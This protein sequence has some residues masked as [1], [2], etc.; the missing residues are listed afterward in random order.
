MFYE[1]PARDFCGALRSEAM[2]RAT[3]G[4]FLCRFLSSSTLLSG[5]VLL[6]GVPAVHGQGIAGAKGS[7]AAL[8]QFQPETPEQLLS[9]GQVAW[10]LDRIT[11]ARRYLKQLADRDPQSAELVLLRKQQGLSVFLDLQRD[12]RLHPESQQL[13]K[14]MQLAIVQPDSAAL[15]QRVSDLSLGGARGA[16]AV[17]DLLVAGDAAV[18]ALLAAD[19]AQPAGKAAHAFLENHVADYGNGLLQQ[20]ESADAATAVRILTLLGGSAREEL[21][22]P[23]VRWQFHSDSGVSAAA[24]QAVRR[25]SRG[26]IR[27]ATAV[28]AAELLSSESEV[29][30]SQAAGVSSSAGDAAGAGSGLSGLPLAER[31]LADAISLQPAAE[32]ALQLQQVLLAAGAEPLVTAAAGPLAGRP[33]AEVLP[34]LGSALDLGQWPAAIECLR[35]LSAQTLAP[36]EAAAATSVLSAAVLSPDVRVRVLAAVTARRNKLQA[37]SAVFAS[38]QVLSAAAQAMPQ[39]EA[40]VIAPDDQLS[41]VLRQL[42]EDQKYTVKVAETGP[43]GFER[44]VECLHSEVIFLSLYPSRWSAATTLANLRAD[45]RTRNCPVVLIGRPSQESQALALQ[46]IHGN[47]YFMSEPIG[48]RS[49]PSQLRNLNLRSL[50]TV[51]EREYLGTLAAPPQSAVS[52]QQ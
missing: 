41:L 42:L 37:G 32:R 9:A 21:A 26:R 33:A 17:T 3:R 39:S 15:V 18:P 8:L 6:S 12:Q 16:D 30:L 4:G 44:A 1:Q 50:L 47:V 11:D 43:Q 5:I 45:V 25:L 31:L 13:L 48:V 20:L 51:E 14:T 10:K 29:I 35:N 23:L 40:V 49:F 36:S 22:L 7:R 46:E 19:P 38:E 27:T 52:P 34:I 24:S 28:E 2:M